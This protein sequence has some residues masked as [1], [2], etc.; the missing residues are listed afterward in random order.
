MLMDPPPSVS[1]RSNDFLSSS[2]CSTLRPLIPANFLASNF[3]PVEAGGAETADLAGAVAAFFI[4]S[5]RYIKSSKWICY[6][7]YTHSYTPAGNFGNPL[8]TVPCVS[9]FQQEAIEVE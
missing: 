1:N 8:S 2:I 3:P 7:I 6:K 9:L 5:I 4:R